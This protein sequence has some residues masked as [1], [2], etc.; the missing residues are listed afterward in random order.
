MLTRD[1]F[2]E[3]LKTINLAT[4]PDPQEVWHINPFSKL[5]RLLSSVAKK[6]L[7]SVLGRQELPSSIADITLGTYLRCC[8]TDSPTQI[9]RLIS[10]DLG[11]ESLSLEQSAS[12]YKAWAPQLEQLTKKVED[13][14]PN[15]SHDGMATAIWQQVCAHHQVPS[16]LWMVDSLAKRF[17]I[18]YDG[19]LNM[20]MADVLTALQIDA[21]NAEYQS[22][23]D[24]MSK[25]KLKSRK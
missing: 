2:D 4:I 14:Q 19:A 3:Q 22:R 25:Q 20:A 18:S 1:L 21:C 15:V 17:Q 24:D 16:H 11:I 9:I 8:Q 7:S 6:V 13:A 10:H 12:W 5:I 23:M